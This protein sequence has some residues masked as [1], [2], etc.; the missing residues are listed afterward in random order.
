M[1]VNKMQN[2]TV[3]NEES[4]VFPSSF[5]FSLRNYAFK[6]VICG[7]KIMTHMDLGKISIVD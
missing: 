5:V 6:W 3:M 1:I 2:H 4:S 7:S